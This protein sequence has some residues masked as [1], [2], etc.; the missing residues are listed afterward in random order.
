M[1]TKLPIDD[2]P[3]FCPTWDEIK[4]KAHMYKTARIRSTGQ[5]VKLCGL[6]LYKSD[7]AFLAQSPGFESHE[8]LTTEQLCDFCL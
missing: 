1:M 7:P 6:I 2:V 4:D 5:Y 3:C 8:I